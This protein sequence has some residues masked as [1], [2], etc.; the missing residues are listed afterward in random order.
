LRPWTIGTP[1]QIYSSVFG[2]IGSTWRTGP[3]VLLLLT[4][5]RAVD[6]FL[7]K[8]SEWTGLR[9]IAERIIRSA[10]EKEERALEGIRKI[11]GDERFT[12][13]K[14][15]IAA[16]SRALMKWN[17]FRPAL[18]Y[19]KAEEAA[20]AVVEYQDLQYTLARCADPEAAVEASKEFRAG[21]GDCAARLE[22]VFGRKALLKLEPELGV[23]L[24][25]AEEESWGR[26]DPEALKRSNAIFGSLVARLQAERELQ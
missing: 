7:K 6:W 13:L 17:P 11:V 2:A 5:G 14:M 16:E 19:Q 3:Q 8:V 20:K 4:V 12:A 24:E 10:R 26:A 22:S 25:A 9:K 15:Q 21:I 23:F 1:D 18:P